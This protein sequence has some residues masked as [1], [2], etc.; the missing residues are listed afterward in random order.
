MDRLIEFNHEFDN[1][2][3]PDWFLKWTIGL[4]NRSL[5]E[6]KEIAAEMLQ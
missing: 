1:R 6:I 4:F 3:P 2:V 5:E